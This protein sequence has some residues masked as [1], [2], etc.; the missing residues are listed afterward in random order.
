D[1]VEYFFAAPAV[2][3]DD[4]AMT[5]TT[6]IIEVLLRHH[7][8][9]ADEHHPLEAETLFQIAQ[10]LWHSLGIAPVALK[11]VMRDRPS[12]NHNSSDQHLPIA[13]LAVTAMAIGTQLWR[14]VPFKICRG[15]V[16][17]HQ[18]DLQR[19]QIAQVHKQLELNL[20]LTR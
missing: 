1:I 7:A 6:Q 9:V 4:V 12:G 8:A 20:P 18:I 11:H 10:H 2:A 17:K 19:K 13:R 5:A 14:S 16:V 3:T 15:Q